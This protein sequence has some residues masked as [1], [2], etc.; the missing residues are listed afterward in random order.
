MTR[1]RGMPAAYRALL[2]LMPRAVREQ[3]GAEIEETFAE[4]W[5]GA[6]GVRGR[7]RTFVRAF[8]GLAVAIVLEWRDNV[9]GTGRQQ[10]A[11]HRGRNDM[12][13]MIRHVRH[14]VRSLARTPS[15]A[16]SAVLLLGLGVGSVTT[17]FTVVD[18]VLLRPLPYPEAERLFEVQNG[19]HTGLDFDTWDQFRSV[20]M[21]A[22]ASIDDAS[23][24]GVARPQRVRQALIS[25]DFFTLFGGRPALGRLFVAEDFRTADGVVLSAGTWERLFGADPEVAGRTIVVNGEPRVVIGVLSPEF[26]QPEAFGSGVD[27]WRPIDRTEDWYGDRSYVNLSVAGRIAA[28]TSLEAVDAEMQA[29]AEQRARDF[30]DRYVLRDGRIHD[31]PIV[32]LQEATVGDVRQGLTLILGAVTLLLLIAC[33]NVAHLFMARGI[34]RIREM[35]TRRALGASMSM[36]TMQLLVESVLIGAGG[37][38]LGVALAIL[39]VRTFQLLSPEGLPRMATLAVD[40][41]VLLFAIT[42]ALVTSLLF[43][44]LPALR[45]AG[46]HAMAALQ[47]GGRGTESRAAHRARAGLVVAEVALSLVLVAQAGLLLR[48][49][50]ALHAQELGFRTEGIWTLPL[51]LSEMKDGEEYARRMEAVRAALETVPGVRMASFGQTM[52]LEF[53]GGGSCCWTTFS[54]LTADEEGELTRMH[55]VGPGY[56]EMLELSFLA[57]APWAAGSERVQPTPIVI[58]EALAIRFFGSAQ[59]AVNREISWGDATGRVVGVAADNRHYGHDQPARPSLYMHAAAVPYASGRAHMGVLVDV[60]D[61]ALAERLRDAVWSVEPDQPVPLVRPLEEWAADA[62][63]RTR[64]ESLLFSVFGAVAL[65]LV[66]GGLYG[67]LLYSVGRRRRELGIRLALGDAPARLER[68]V[69]SQGLRTAAL[70]GALGLAGAWGFGR[71]LQSRLFGVQAGDPLTLGG[72]LAVLLLV[73]AAAS[74]LPARKAAGTDPMEALRAE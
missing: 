64:F 15:F 8:G 47:R 18:H 6:R 58:N 72:A 2:R 69:L 53:T 45:L 52:P 54:R 59:A 11:P 49:F 31:L 40:V 39:G 48:S 56:F 70:G 62:T 43:G 24:T 9:F 36:L 32:P 61:D 46:G 5:T 30:P 35:A 68:R 3:D 4:V 16:L 33:T 67:T 17:I 60:A 19:A 23:L 25:R 37:A 12:D 65:M 7:L 22:A 74:W 41:R 55:P 34:A 66:A 63:A 44:L 26:Q 10:A 29:Y 51:N 21:W 73:T 42:L 38:L 13:A 28:G 57:G 14:G 50:A 1:R 27:V 71:L 20:E